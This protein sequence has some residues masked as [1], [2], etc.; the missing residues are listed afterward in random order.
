MKR[1]FLYTIIIGFFVSSCSPAG[2][3]GSADDARIN[4]NF[5]QVNDVYEIAP[6]SG[7]KEG[8]LAKVASIKKKYLQQNPNTFLL[9]AGDF[10]SPSVY[11]SLKYQGKNI[12]GKQMIEAM[13][14]AGFDLAIFGNHEFDIKES[15]LQERINESGFQWI[16]SNT[17]HRVNG[18]VV[19]FAKNNPAGN[20][21][22]PVSYIKTITDADGTTARIGFIGLTLPFNK[23]GYVS[24]TDALSVAKILYERLKDSTDAVVAITHQTME[25]D[26]ILAREIPGL[27]A[28][29]GGHEHDQRYE[30]IGNV[31]IT[32]AMA[33]ARTAFV[34]TLSVNKKR[35]KVKVFTRV[36]LLDETVALD[37]ATTA[38]V[39]RWEGIA[40]S[41]YASLGFDAKKIVIK[42]GESL[43]GR[44]A[45]IRSRP[46]NLTRL[47]ITAMTD[48]APH[49]DVVIMNAGSIRVD[50]M[51]H[52]PVTQYDIIRT[53]PFGG[54][55]REVDIKGSLLQKILDA[56]L[57]NNGSG[58]LLH[59]NKEVSFNTK[60]NSWDIKNTAINPSKTYRVALPDFL[61][62]GGEANLGFLKQ[63]NT[64]IVKTWPDASPDIRLAIIRYLEKRN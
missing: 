55:I 50:D 5:I 4:I 21:P 38:V 30:E 59:L 24:Y 15:E 32:K 1:I 14:A 13:N 20:A 52:M 43:D 7:G 23:A 12:R 64:E 42:T 61:L 48:A 45:E 40:E 63:G 16:A 18:T 53:L 58:G 31:P 2:K 41:S 47:I 56:G 33:N 62:T 3:T 49:A 35:K 25:E 11:N 34:V 29:M 51:L 17:Y 27:A 44:E 57:K 6:L 26:E 8:G 60:T 10:V 28:I 19:S 54:G 22:F 37:S 9:M 46:T 36:E 39:N